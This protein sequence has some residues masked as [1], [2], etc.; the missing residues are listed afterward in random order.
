MEAGRIIRDPLT[1][2]R[3]FGSAGVTFAGGSAVFLSACGS[4]QDLKDEQEQLADTPEEDVA[5]LNDALSLELTAVEAYTQALP[6]LQGAVAAVGASFRDRPDVAPCPPRRWPRVRIATG[7]NR[8][9]GGQDPPSGT[10]P[11]KGRRVIVTE[12]SHMQRQPK[13]PALR[14]RIPIAPASSRRDS[15]LLASRGASGNRRGGN[16]RILLDPG[17]SRTAVARMIWLLTLLAAIFGPS[18]IFGEGG[19]GDR[20]PGRG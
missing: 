10:P 11:P 19:P 4:N 7:S 9:A 17:R 12:G 8:L 20:N 13:V 5:I 6:L 15:R 2:R 3:F 18:L 1:R 14:R 16:G